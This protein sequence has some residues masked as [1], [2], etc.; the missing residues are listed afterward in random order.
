MTPLAQPLSH[1][2]WW[3]QQYRE[4]PH[5][6]QPPMA[7]TSKTNTCKQTSQ[8][9]YNS[10]KTVGKE[11][12]GGGGVHS[13]IC[14]FVLHAIYLFYLFTPLWPTAHVRSQEYLSCRLRLQVSAAVSS[15]PEA[16]GRQSPSPPRIWSCF[17]LHSKLCSVHY[18]QS[19][20]VYKTSRKIQKTCMYEHLFS[21]LCTTVHNNEALW[22]L[23]LV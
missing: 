6:I 22:I 21:A 3:R 13:L 1:V 16:V 14:V 4:F 12:W 11:D 10:Y 2:W 17:L 19:W 7:A 5:Q 23:Y 9:D 15:P 8:E 20:I 18:C